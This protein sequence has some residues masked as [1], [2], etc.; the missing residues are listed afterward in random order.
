M[1]IHPLP[2][3]DRFLLTSGRAHKE[4]FSC[5][6]QRMIAFLPFTL[7]HRSFLESLLDHVTVCYL[8]SWVSGNSN[9]LIELFGSPCAF[10]E[11]I[12]GKRFSA[13]YECLDLL[14]IWRSV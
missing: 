3:P 11:A 9:V 10:V 2:Q 12:F 5:D 1:F 13:E 6:T 4:Y 8:W 7:L 14:Q